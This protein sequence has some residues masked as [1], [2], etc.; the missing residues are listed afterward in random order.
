MELA[1]IGDVPATELAILCDKCNNIS[2]NINICSQCGNIFSFYDDLSISGCSTDVVIDI[3]TDE[4]SEDVQEK[5]TEEINRTRIREVNPYGMF[6][7][8]L[9]ETSS[10][11]LDLKAA[12][13]SWSK[14]SDSQ[15]E[16]YKKKSLEDREHLRMERL[17]KPVDNKRSEEDVVNENQE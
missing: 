17:D 5:E 4:V 9:K 7:I 12:A 14:L 2:E 10:E 16:K 1:E 6:L 11:T 13:L 8:E 3:Q 15:R